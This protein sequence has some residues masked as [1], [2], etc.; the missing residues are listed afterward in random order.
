MNSCLLVLSI[1]LIHFSASATG[2]WGWIAV[3]AGGFSAGLYTTLI[4]RKDSK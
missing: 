4:E 2:I 1:W 3:A